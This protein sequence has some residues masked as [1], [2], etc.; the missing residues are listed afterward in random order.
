MHLP[1]NQNF[2]LENAEFNYL[3]KNFQT[4][5]ENETFH[6]VMPFQFEFN[7]FYFEKNLFLFCLFPFW[8]Y[9]NLTCP[10]GNVFDLLFLLKML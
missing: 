10:S 6:L 4:K 3:K 9:L 5:F 2:P 8:K 7:I 1:Q